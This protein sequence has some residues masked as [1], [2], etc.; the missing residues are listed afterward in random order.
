[1]DY[2]ALLGVSNTASADELK[3][4]YRGQAMQ[5]HPDRNPGNTAAEEKF[6]SISAAYEVLS[7]P[8][9]RAHYDR[10]GH[11]AFTTHG[12]GGGPSGFG[13]GFGAGHFSDL[14]E[15]VFSS[16]MGGGRR[17]QQRGSTKGQ[18]LSYDL[19]IS[20]E[21]AF[22]GVKKDITINI[23]T[24]CAPCHGS[25]ST[26]RSGKK[27]CAAC[28][29]HGVV[30]MQQGFFMMER[31]CGKCH[32]T[33]SVI[34]DPCKTCRGAGLVET[35][36]HLEIPVPAGVDEG[37]RLRLS[38]K[39]DAGPG[40]AARGD[41][42]VLIHLKEHKLFQRERHDLHCRIPISVV[43]AI[44]GASF[45][46]PT[47]DGETSTVEIPEGTQQGDQIKVKGKG[48]PIS[49]GRRGDLYLHAFLETPKNLSAKQKE[50]LK[51]FYKTVD[52]KKSQPEVAGFWKTVKKLWGT[53]GDA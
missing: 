6:K 38:G 24:D 23:A 44:L 22:S 40:G 32:G 26:S 17:Q 12:D 1:M 14:F 48:M 11:E 31:P 43:D 4:A 39:G 18:D 28:H 13:G 36:E 51:A 47:I 45:S 5:Y 15:E 19:Q 7:N 16:F 3:K 20:L 33:G 21:E 29:G 41:L 37:M 53:A 2:Y 30:R 35:M 9:K 52:A 27:P 49:Q 46:M 8:E 25:G 34:K 10:L 50:V 42:Y